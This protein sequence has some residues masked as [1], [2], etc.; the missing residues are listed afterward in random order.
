[1][2]FKDLTRKQLEEFNL[3]DYLQSGGDINQIEDDKYAIE[4]FF[5]HLST[6]LGERIFE[7][8]CHPDTFT[9]K[10]DI[11]NKFVKYWPFIPF[12]KEN[13][14]IIIKKFDFNNNVLAKDYKDN[15][16]ITNWHYYF[17]SGQASF[18]LFIT[19]YEHHPDFH[20]KLKDKG[21]WDCNMWHYF[22]NYITENIMGD[23]V[24]H[25]RVFEILMTEY[26]EGL[27]EKNNRDQTP[28]EMIVSRQAIANKNYK[29]EHTEIFDGFTDKIKKATQYIS[30]NI[31]MVDTNKLKS[32]KI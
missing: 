27:L 24:P 21:M 25:E 29:S 15:E 28:L 4:Y 32:N 12:N 18:P 22:A 5:A 11:Q 9:Y 20:T 3:K 10:T 7:F 17:M 23:D 2:K 31:N 13:P 19:A 1:M 30:L 14:E 6:E 26:P 8:L 16:L